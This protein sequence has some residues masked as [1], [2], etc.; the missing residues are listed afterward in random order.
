MRELEDWLRSKLKNDDLEEPDQIFGHL[1]NSIFSDGRSNDPIIKEAHLLQG[2]NSI[3]RKGLNY[4]LTSQPAERMLK[5]NCL[6][7]L[8]NL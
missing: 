3:Y 6:T 2:S 1:L 4:L 8:R 5:D 7:M